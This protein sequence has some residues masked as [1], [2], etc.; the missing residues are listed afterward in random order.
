ASSRT[1]LTK[2][3]TRLV[4]AW[5]WPSM[6]ASRSSVYNSGLPGISHRSLFTGRRLSLHS[7]SPSPSSRDTIVYAVS[8]S[9]S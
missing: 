9:S 7:A 2:S 3:D 1:Q 6:T 4:L 8:G 5:S